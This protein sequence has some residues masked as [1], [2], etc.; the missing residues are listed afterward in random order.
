[1]TVTSTDPDTVRRVAAAN[2][3]P[4]FASTVAAFELITSDARAHGRDSS[5]TRVLRA[6]GPYQASGFPVI[7]FSADSARFGSPAAPLYARVDRD[8]RI[9]GIS[10]R[11]TTTRT[12]T[13]RVD[14]YDLASV[15]RHFPDV[16]ADAPIVGFTSIS[17]RDTVRSKVG[18]AT[19][20]V[21]YGRPAAR[22]RAVFTHGVL[23]DTLWRAGANAA[24]QF[25]TD[26]DL[27]IGGSTL[28]AGAYSMW[29]RASP[30]DARFE[31]V[32][33]SQTG[34]WGTEHHADRDVLSVP[35][36]RASATTPL[37]RFTITL[38]SSSRQSELRFTWST[39]ELVAP[40][41]VH[42]AGPSGT[43]QSRP[44]AARTLGSS[45]SS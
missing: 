30:D 38:P 15:V 9:E 43:T 17:P 21:D 7:F 10:A 31:L 18:D 37:E 2:V 20:T 4:L 19:I 24:T 16:T 32:F 1:V 23:G 36:R 3:F 39:T 8:G 42:A 44:S 12:E 41:S 13:R 25:T 11:A 29:V 5:V 45:R 22:G 14:A 6:F 33:N 28:R 35:L 27:T 34:Q 26:R 40:I